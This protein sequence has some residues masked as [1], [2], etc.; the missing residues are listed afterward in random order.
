MKH[1]L[2]L[3]TLFCLTSCQLDDD[4]FGFHHHKLGNGIYAR[5]NH[6]IC[7]EKSKFENGEI[8]NKYHVLVRVSV[9]DNFIVGMADAHI[10]RDS[11]EYTN[12][13]QARQELGIMISRAKS[14][15]NQY[16]ISLSKIYKTEMYEACIITN[17]LDFY[18]N[19]F[20]FP[21]TLSPQYT[22][23]MAR[24]Y[25]MYYSDIFRDI[26]DIVYRHIHCK[27]DSSTL[28]LT[29]IS[30]KEPG[31]VKFSDIYDLNVTNNIPTNILILITNA[32][33]TKKEVYDILEAR[34][35]EDYSAKDYTENLTN[36]F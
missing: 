13:T 5:V 30:P 35:D 11:G 33:V 21:V 29:G 24:I 9:S 25:H 3:T 34:K 8:I 2:I 32:Y 28:Q 36:W 20:N 31:I 16:D 27:Y 7:K 14:F 26:T 19:S 10:W 15:M 4:M 22:N 12:I 18:T 23:A 1:F 17:C 6:F